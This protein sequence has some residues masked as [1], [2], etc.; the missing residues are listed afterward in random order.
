M[1]TIVV[2]GENDLVGLFAS[3]EDMAD[4]ADATLYK[5]PS[6]YHSWMLANPQHGAD[7]MRQLLAAELGDVVREA[8]TGRE[9]GWTPC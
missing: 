5:V 4:R 1:P 8:C 7:M 6:A 3:A 2:H 9:A